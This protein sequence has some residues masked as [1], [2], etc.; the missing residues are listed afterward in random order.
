M[1]GVC[2][3]DLLPGLSSE[4]S[5][6]AASAEAASTVLADI[7]VPSSGC[8]NAI[9]KLPRCGRWQSLTHSRRRPRRAAPAGESPAAHARRNAVG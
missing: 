2:G 7:P 3:G 6:V 5:S 8:A 9:K 1:L 4:A